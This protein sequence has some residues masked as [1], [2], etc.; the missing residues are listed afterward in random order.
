M[1]FYFEI[2][3]NSQKKKNAYNFFERS[4]ISSGHEILAIPGV[5]GPDGWLSGSIDSTF[6]FRVGS[7]AYSSSPHN[8]LRAGYFLSAGWYGFGTSYDVR[9]HQRPAL[10]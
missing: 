10:K 6:C 7:W 4:T 3:K 8:T 5:F 9:W 2:T 1:S